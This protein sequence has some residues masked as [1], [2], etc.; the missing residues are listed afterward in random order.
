MS[1]CPPTAII[2][3]QDKAM[4]NAIEI[5]FP[6]AR[7]RWCI[8]HIL[9]KVPQ[10]LGGY[11]EHEDMSFDILEVV[12]DSLTREDFEENWGSFIKKYNLESNE[13]LV[14]LYDE[15]HRWVPTFVKDVFWAGMSSTQRSESMHSFFDGYINSKT[16]LKQFVEQYENAL[17]K[18]VEKEIEAD[19]SSLHSY[20]PCLSQYEFEQQFQSTYTLDKFR[21]VQTE[22]VGMIYCNL[23]LSKEADGFSEYEVREDVL[24]GAMKKRVIFKV[25]FKENGNEKTLEEDYSTQQSKHI[26]EM[27]PFQSY[28]S[29]SYQ[30][31][32][33]LQG[34]F[35]FQPN[36]SQGGLFTCQP[37]ILQGM[38]PFQ[39]QFH[40]SPAWRTSHQGFTNMLNTIRP[41][42][43]QKPPS[44]Y[45]G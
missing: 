3:D 9:K 12:F 28:V 32:P 19:S 26:A 20:I 7:H 27:S 44:F 45:D 5:V 38:Q 21:E 4:K 10:K 11:K 35:P 41:P 15:R 8:W 43:I 22:L 6:N 31:N 18:K 2:T 13:W 34:N 14:G 1:D 16:T 33:L 29:Q 42:D 36:I 39:G 37:S 40:F 24:C 17:A 25:C 30:S 23:S